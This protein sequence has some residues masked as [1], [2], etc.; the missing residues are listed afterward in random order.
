M[1]RYSIRSLLCVACLIAVVP[2]SYLQAA[3][4]LSNANIFMFSRPHPVT[5]MVFAGASGQA[6]STRE[7]K[8]KV[9]LLHFWSIQCPAC[10]MEEPLL[11]QLKRTY[12]GSGLEI[13]GVNLVDPPDAIA[14]YAA[15]NRI[16]FPVVFDGGKGYS[17]KVVNMS[18]KRTA[19]LINPSQ[20]ALLEVPG[21]PTTYILDCRG[22]AIGYTVGAAKWDAASAQA[23]IQ[24]LLVDQKT[25]GSPNAQIPSQRYT[26]R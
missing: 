20:E 16:P 5:D 11:D 12:G 24:K 8:G 10:R 2:I 7:L 17:L 26:M 23:M 21:F 9:V 18:G 3:D 19:F 4:N 1:K 22:S 15:S 25:C 13:L 14:R 6:I